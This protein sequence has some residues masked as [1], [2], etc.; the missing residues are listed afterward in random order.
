MYEAPE[1]PLEILC[2]TVMSL[3]CANHY[4]Y[5]IYLQLSTLEGATICTWAG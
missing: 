5:Y 3:F 2:Y 1:K 4:R